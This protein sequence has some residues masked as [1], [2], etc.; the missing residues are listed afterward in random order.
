M[1]RLIDPRVYNKR[2]RPGK[3]EGAAHSLSTPS[4]HFRRYTHACD[5]SASSRTASLFDVTTKR[6]VRFTWNISGD[7]TEVNVAV[8]IN[9]IGTVRELTMVS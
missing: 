3:A 6:E 5:R 4:C 7:A 9:G 1:N 2:E 8:Y